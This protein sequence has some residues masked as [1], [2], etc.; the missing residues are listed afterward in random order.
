MS[1]SNC[2]EDWL[3]IRD[4]PNISSPFLYERKLCGKETPDPIMSTGN[5]IY[6]RFTTN[7]IAQSSGYQI[8]LRAGKNEFIPAF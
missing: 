4:G 2:N 5:E 8:K 1:C 7:A 6:I 3:E